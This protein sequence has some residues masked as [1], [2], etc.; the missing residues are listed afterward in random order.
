[1]WAF[2]HNSHKIFFKL[3]ILFNHLSHKKTNRLKMW[4]QESTECKITNTTF[5]FSS[6]FY[7]FLSG[8]IMSLLSTFPW[9]YLNNISIW[10]CGNFNICYYTYNI[11]MTIF[12][13]SFLLSLL[14]IFDTGCEIYMQVWNSFLLFLY[15]KV[16]MDNY[17]MTVID[18]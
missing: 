17:N 4:P 5:C 15:E 10:C 16:S 11:Y 1:M 14:F 7:F 18:V 3:K 9:K 8:F 6:P 12:F 2:K 13:L